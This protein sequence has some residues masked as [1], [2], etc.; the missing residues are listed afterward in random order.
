MILS[1]LGPIGGLLTVLGTCMSAG[2]AQAFGGR[3]L[4]S[5]SSTPCPIVS[6]TPC[7]TTFCIPNVVTCGGMVTCNT[8]PVAGG[9]AQYCCPVAYGTVDVKVK[10]IIKPKPNGDGFDVYVPSDD[11]KAPTLLSGA[12]PTAEE[13]LEYI[14][15]QVKPKTNKD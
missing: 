2:D 12:T 9:F 8:F 4:R 14:A 5:A 3:F 13:L 15:N 7:P 10:R 1:R 11:P 6:Y